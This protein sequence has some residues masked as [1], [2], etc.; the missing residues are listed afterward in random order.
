MTVVEYATK[1]DLD[2]WD[3]YTIMTRAVLTAMPE[4]VG[5]RSSD[6]E[7]E[8]QITAAAT[9]TAT[10][11][12]HASAAPPPAAQQKAPNPKP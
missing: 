4:I 8:A 12:A 11:T 5:L 1:P 3:S 2:Y 6:Y 10:A 9:A 7:N